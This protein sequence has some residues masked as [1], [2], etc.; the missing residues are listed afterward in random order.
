ML[1]FRDDNLE[2]SAH[3]ENEGMKPLGA[4]PNYDQ[5]K[6][7]FWAIQ[8]PERKQYLKMREL[9][10]FFFLFFWGLPYHGFPLSLPTRYPRQHVN[11]QSVVQ[12][13]KLLSRKCRCGAG[14]CFRKFRE[15]ELMKFLTAFWTMKKTLQDAYVARLQHSICKPSWRNMISV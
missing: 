8:Q 2:H 3:K 10:I 6:R 12:V 1:Q 4:R 15:Q 13:R 9:D 14:N 5:R 7:Q 11:G